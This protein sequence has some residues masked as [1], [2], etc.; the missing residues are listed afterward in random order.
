MMKFLFV[1]MIGLAAGYHLGFKDARLHHTTVV[2]RIIDQVGGSSRGKYS[3][4][5]D[6]QM[7]RQEK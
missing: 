7:E 4:D 2:T 5:I 1:L 3:N 6:K